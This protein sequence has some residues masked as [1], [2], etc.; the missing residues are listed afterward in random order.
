MGWIGAG[1]CEVPRYVPG[2]GRG[3]TAAANTFEATASRFFTTPGVLTPGDGVGITTLFGE[4]ELQGAM[5]SR[6]LIPLLA[7]AR[8]GT[9]AVRA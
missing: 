7:G 6:F 8:V 4:R 2:A 5:R 3:E 1:G 9:R